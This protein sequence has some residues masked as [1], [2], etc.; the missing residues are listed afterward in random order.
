[1]VRVRC[2]GAGAAYRAGKILPALRIQLFTFLDVYSE[3][4][5]PTMLVDLN[6]KTA[7][8]LEIATYVLKVPTCKAFVN[9]TFILH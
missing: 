2:A 6:R 4:S 9:A 7:I 5:K 1:M 3:L 8:D